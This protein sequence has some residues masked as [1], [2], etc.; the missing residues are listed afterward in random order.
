MA[1]ERNDQVPEKTE[2]PKNKEFEIEEVTDLEG[3]SGGNVSGNYVIGDTGCGG[4]DGCSH[5]G[6]SSCG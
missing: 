1:N 5:T 4:C 6:C 2:K 3:V